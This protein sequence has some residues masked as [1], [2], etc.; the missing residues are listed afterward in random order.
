MKVGRRGEIPRDG[1][2]HREQTA[3]KGK[4]EMAVQETT[5]AAE[6][7]HAGQTLL[8]A[9]SNRELNGRPVRSWAFMAQVK[10]RVDRLDE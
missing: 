10:F 1:K 6:T 7:T 4:G 3:R 5:G 8:G 2:C 9:R